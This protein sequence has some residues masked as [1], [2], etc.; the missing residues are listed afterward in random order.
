MHWTKRTW[1]KIEKNA[2]FWSAMFGGLFLGWWYLRGLGYLTA[3]FAALCLIFAFIYSQAFIREY[4]K[5]KKARAAQGA[6]PSKAK[7]K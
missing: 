7:R 3:A 5:A 2:H 4:H 1:A 6:K